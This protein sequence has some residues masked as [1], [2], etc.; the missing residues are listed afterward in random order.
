MDNTHR[1]LGY[2]K[3]L[4]SL[5]HKESSEKAAF[6]EMCDYKTAPPHLLARV[7]HCVIAL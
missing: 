2:K 5:G 6:P 3:L 4:V 7:R 1:E